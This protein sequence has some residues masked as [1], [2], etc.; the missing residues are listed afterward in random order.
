[1][2]ELICSSKSLSHPTATRSR[3]STFTG[4]IVSHPVA[5]HHFLVSECEA[6]F[7]APDAL[8]WTGS[9]TTSCLAPRTNRFGVSKGS[10]TLA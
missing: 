7:G 3:L 2:R 1:M 4:E 10:A 8:L 5:L 6:G 9:Y